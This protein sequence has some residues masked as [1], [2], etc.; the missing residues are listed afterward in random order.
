MQLISWDTAKNTFQSGQWFHGRIYEKRCDLSPN[1]EKLIYFA[2]KHYV[3][4]RT[5]TPSNTWTAISKPPYLTAIEFWPGDNSTL[6]GGGLFESDKRVVINAYRGESKALPLF[7]LLFRLKVISKQLSVGD[8]MYSTRLARDGWTFDRDVS[9]ASLHR[10]NYGV[11]C[12][13]NQAESLALLATTTRGKSVEHEAYEVIDLKAGQRTPLKNVRWADWDQ[14]GRFV[15]AR[16]GCIFT[17]RYDESNRLQVVQLAD[18][19]DATFA[20]LEAPDEA[21]VW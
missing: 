11:R 14:H 2:A 3:A 10:T 20:R 1:G 21:K 5:T 8:E 15:F 16:R 19:N 17:A 4:T 9:P 12:K 13:V 6:C 7:H 18:F